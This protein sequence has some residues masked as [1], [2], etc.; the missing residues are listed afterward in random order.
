M[1]LSMFIEKQPR[2]GTSLYGVCLLLY[3]LYA[4]AFV[5]EMAPPGAAAANFWSLVIPAIIITS[6]LVYPTLL[7]WLCV[8]L[9]FAFCTCASGYYLLLWQGSFPGFIIGVAIV[10]ILAFVCVGLLR[11]EC[12]DY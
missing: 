8:I 3:V 6:Q 1:K 12:A 2:R 10:M 4:I 11:L 9:G 5:A 7:G